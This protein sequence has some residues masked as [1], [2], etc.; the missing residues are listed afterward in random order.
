MVDCKRSNGQS[1]LPI[2]Y[3]VEPSDVNHQS[4]SYEEAFCKHENCFDECTVMKWKEALTQVGELHGWHVNKEA[5]GHQGELVETIVQTVSLNLKKK[6]MFTSDYLVMIDDHLNEMMRL[7]NVGSND[8]RIVGILGMGGIG[9]TTIA[10]SIYN[11]LLQDFKNC[12]SFL[13][14]VRE[15]VKQYKDKGIVDLQNQLL[16]DTLKPHPL[17]TNVNDGIEVIKS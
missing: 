2:F 10:K 16:N 15:K 1:I 7:L 11:K 9:K 13:A 3:D 17:I 12:C 6:C 4:G 5:D 8:V 14:D